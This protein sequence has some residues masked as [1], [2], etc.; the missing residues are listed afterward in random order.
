M[1]ARVR[2][3]DAEDGYEIVL[4]DEGVW[5][6]DVF[7]EVADAL[8]SLHAGT[9]TEWNGDVGAWQAN[10]AARR[11]HGEVIYLQA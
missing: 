3:A 1:I 5:T 9:Y 6:C 10:D 8:N 4:D 11:L 7:P 2:V